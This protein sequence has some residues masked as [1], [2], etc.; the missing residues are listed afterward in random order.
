MTG[1]E[2]R[3]ALG[4]GENIAAPVEVVDKIEAYLLEKEGITN[5]TVQQINA[6]YTDP[7]NYQFMEDLMKEKEKEADDDMFYALDPVY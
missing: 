7:A 6:L 4:R 5:P 2:I 3:L 1:Y